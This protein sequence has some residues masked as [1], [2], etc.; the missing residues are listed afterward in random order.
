MQRHCGVRPLLQCCHCPLQDEKALVPQCPILSLDAR[1]D[2]PRSSIGIGGV[3]VNES[4]SCT[5]LDYYSVLSIRTGKQKEEKELAHRPNKAYV[6]V[7]PIA[8]AQGL[9]GRID[10]FR[11]FPRGMYS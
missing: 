2:C 1:Q 11:F 10:T 7:L 9:T 8:E 3:Y 6:D 4:A 5:G